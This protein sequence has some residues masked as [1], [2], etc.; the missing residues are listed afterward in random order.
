MIL[1]NV[2][3]QIMADMKKDKSQG[4]T[5]AANQA[6]NSRGFRAA[7]QNVQSAA[8]GSAGKA[9]VSGKGIRVRV[10]R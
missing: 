3:E 5:Q 4:R 8:K 2:M 6:N 10:I 1:M 9:P 7:S